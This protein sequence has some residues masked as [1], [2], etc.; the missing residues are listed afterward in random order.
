[1]RSVDTP[2]TDRL[3]PALT[4]AGASV[5]TARTTPDATVE[6]RTIVSVYAGVGTNPGTVTVRS[7]ER[8]I[9]SSSRIETVAGAVASGVRIH[10]R[11]GSRPAMRGPRSRTGELVAPAGALVPGVSGRSGRSVI[12]TGIASATPPRRKTP[13]LVTRATPEVPD[14]TTTPR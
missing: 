8:P 14:V 9:G 3:I 6:V 7:T 10:S 11:S 1:M 13:A 5:P 4:V 2:R 12:A